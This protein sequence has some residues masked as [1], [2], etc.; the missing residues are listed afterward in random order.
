MKKITVVIPS[1]NQPILLESC[2][3]SLKNQTVND[4]DVII[5]DDCSPDTESFNIGKKYFDAIKTKK[6]SGPATAR[7]LGISKTDT[8][9][10]AFTDSDCQVSSDWVE[11]IIQNFNDPKTDVIM[12]RVW[13]PKSNYLGDA[14]SCLGYPAGG[15]PGIKVMYDVDQDNYINH[16]STC[17]CALRTKLLKDVGLFDESFPTPGRE[18]TEFSCRLIS[19]GFKV[20]YCDDIIVE[21]IPR[22]S[23]S[24]LI[25]MNINRGRGTVHLEKTI[26]KDQ[27]RYFT[28]LRYR[29]T[30]KIFKKYMFD[31]KFPMIVVLFAISYLSLKYG[32][33]IEARK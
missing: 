12:G 14:I 19:K 29:S 27:L 23:I 28:R 20:R 4:F 13:I 3:K 32:Q 21:H 30:L 10:I 7:N 6:N 24:S 25:K 2:L 31:V 17:N 8:E 15:W 9:L 5:V 11:R 16:L 22:K 18:D 1:Y 26:P 33:L